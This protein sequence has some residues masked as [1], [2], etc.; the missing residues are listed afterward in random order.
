MNNRSALDVRVDALPIETRR[1]C[2]DVVETRVVKASLYRRVRRKR[3]KGGRR[4]VLWKV[5]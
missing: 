1:S 5:I 3:E 4:T 2:L